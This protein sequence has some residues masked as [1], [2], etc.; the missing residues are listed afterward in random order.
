[1]V[2]RKTCRKYIKHFI[3]FFIY[4]IIKIHLFYSVINHDGSS[5]ENNIYGLYVTYTGCMLHIRAVC[6][7]YGLYVTYTGCML[8]IRAVCILGLLYN[9]LV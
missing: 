8:H 9:A 1:M 5:Y 6:Y 4:K 3:V 2:T 7:I